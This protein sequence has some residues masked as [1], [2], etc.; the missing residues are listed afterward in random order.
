MHDSDFQLLEK[1]VHVESPTFTK[2]ARKY[3]HPGIRTG[4]HPGS[5]RG[6]RRDGQGFLNS[7]PAR[8]TYRT[9]DYGVAVPRVSALQGTWNF[10]D[11]LSGDSVKNLWIAYEA[12]QGR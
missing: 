11:M 2:W 1:M 9:T 10:G 8:R 5:R 7:P 6:R 4:R 12:M 3:G